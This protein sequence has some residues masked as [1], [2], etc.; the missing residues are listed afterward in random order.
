MERGKNGIKIM[1]L[2]KFGLI[3][4]QKKINKLVIDQKKT[5]QNQSFNN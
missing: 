4:K 5:Q 2:K 3:F 1:S